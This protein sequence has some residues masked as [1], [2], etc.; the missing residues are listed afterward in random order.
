MIVDFDKISYINIVYVIILEQGY[1]ISTCCGAVN[2]LVKMSID[3]YGKM[4]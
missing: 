3:E 4:I 2:T 1:S